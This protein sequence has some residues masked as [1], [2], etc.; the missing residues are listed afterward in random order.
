MAAHKFQTMAC[1]MFQNQKVTYSVSESVTR[2]PIELSA[3]QLK[4]IGLFVT[5]GPSHCIALNMGG[6]CSK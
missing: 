1:L 3:G 6:S 5:D 4:T 2:S